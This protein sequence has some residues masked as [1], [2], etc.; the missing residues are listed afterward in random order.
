MSGFVGLRA[1]KRKRNLILTIVLIIPAI[2]IFF[3]YPTFEIDISDP[4]PDENIIP[5]P[6]EDLNSLVSNIEELE[7]NIF[8]KVGRH[9]LDKRLEML[10]GCSTFSRFQP[11]M[12]YQNL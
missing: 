11:C 2:I 3:I 8:Q 4:V 12:C 6:I 10:S 1:R 7:L 9:D 5:D